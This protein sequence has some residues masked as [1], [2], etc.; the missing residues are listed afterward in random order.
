MFLYAKQFFFCCFLALALYSA[1]ISNAAAAAAECKLP[2]NIVG[3]K[4]EVQEKKMEAMDCDLKCRT[5][6]YP[7]AHS[8]LI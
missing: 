6:R 5:T 7:R 3:S 2:V 1:D 8:S 4:D